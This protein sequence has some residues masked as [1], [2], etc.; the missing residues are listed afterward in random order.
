[1]LENIKLAGKKI[2]SF[3]FN[4]SDESKS[5]KSLKGDGFVIVELSAP[6]LSMLHRN[7]FE[8]EYTLSVHGYLNNDGSDTLEECTDKTELFSF[9]IIF[10]LAY[11]LKGDLDDFTQL[12]KDNSWMF[13]KDAHFFMSDYINK[14]LMDTTFRHIRIPLQT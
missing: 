9:D 8:V 13:E 6:S 4:E 2:S 14:F 1:M 3:V 12:S 10:S 5:L 11:H 7:I